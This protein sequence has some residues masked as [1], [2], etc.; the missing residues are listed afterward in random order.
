[1]KYK[2]L[3]AGNIY[4]KGINDMSIFTNDKAGLGA[5]ARLP[6][7]EDILTNYSRAV[8]EA[9]S[10]KK[11]TKKKIKVKADCTYNIEEIPL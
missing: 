8:R 4:L 10:S 11:S 5:F 3:N 6:K 7:I 9:T 2:I 1:M